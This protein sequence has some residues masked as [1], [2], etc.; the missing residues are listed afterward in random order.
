MYP[1]QNE[2]MDVQKLG[3]LTIDSHAPSFH[4]VM[5]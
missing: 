3:A 1:S 4:K 2:L 5:W